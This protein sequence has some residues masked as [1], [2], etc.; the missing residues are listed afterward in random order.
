MDGVLNDI[1]DISV[2][3][4]RRFFSLLRLNAADVNE[5]WIYPLCAISVGEL[6]VAQVLYNDMRTKQGI[7]HESIAEQSRRV[8][9]HKSCLE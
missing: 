6:C 1:Q 8:K 3:D 5:H 7:D 4:K 2:T 9:K